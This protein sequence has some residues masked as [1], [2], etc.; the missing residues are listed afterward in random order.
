MLRS[1]IF[2]CVLLVFIVNVAK[3]QKDRLQEVPDYMNVYSSNRPYYKNVQ[4]ILLSNLSKNGILHFLIL[5]SFSGETIIELAKLEDEYF[6]R[7]LS[8]R[9]NIY[10]AKDKTR[11]EVVEKQK[12]ISKE[13]G[14]LL[15]KLFQQVVILSENTNFELVGTDGAMYYFTVKGASQYSYKTRVIHTLSL[16]SETM[17]LVKL[18]TQLQDMLKEDSSKVILSSEMILEIETLIS[19][20]ER[21][22]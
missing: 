4:K 2:T 5:S 14:I 7:Y 12:P 16:G 17:K 20:F 8:C 1:L 22:K 18:S 21:N 19:E 3:G 6:L 10:Y 11:I 13:H 15:I 9:E